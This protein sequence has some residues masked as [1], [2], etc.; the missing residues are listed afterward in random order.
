MEKYP[1]TVLQF[2][3][4]YKDTAVQI[5]FGTPLVPKELKVFNLYFF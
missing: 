5:S 3:L 1:K 2:R 4:P